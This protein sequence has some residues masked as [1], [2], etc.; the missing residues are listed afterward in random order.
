[1]YQTTLVPLDGSRLAERT[2]PFAETIARAA[3]GRLVLFQAVPEVAFVPRAERELRAVAER[4]RTAGLPVESSVRHGDA[5]QLILDAAAAWRADLIALSSHGHSGIG[6]WLYGSVTDRVVRHAAAPVLLVPATC[7]HPWPDRP[8]RIV[9]PLDGSRLAEE[10]LGPATALAG[11][12]GAGLLLVQALAT[13]TVAP[14]DLDSSW[15]SD[16]AAGA[17]SGAAADIQEAEDVE[18]AF[19]AQRNEAQRY[20]ERIAGRLRT[21]TQAVEVQVM[22]GP[23]AATIAGVARKRG[24]GVIAMTTHG[25][26]VTAESVMGK[27]ATGTLQ[28]SNIPLLLVRPTAVRQ[29]EAQ[30][31]V[32]PAERVPEPAAAIAS[33]APGVSR[34]AQEEEGPRVALALSRRDL[35]LLQ[36]GVERLLGEIHPAEAVYGLMT[37]LRQARAAADQAARTS[38]I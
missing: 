8:D 24:A 12:F 14:P 29:L 27:V 31:E 3:G 30:R 28:R 20:L 16:G 33:A 32:R 2:L 21:G 7:D 22:A 17:T 1:M 26:G 35:D 9:V 18:A 34:E 37:R 15:A 36:R 38:R 11:L 13:H 4:V 23:P 19:T 5:V 25:R 10:A 6:R